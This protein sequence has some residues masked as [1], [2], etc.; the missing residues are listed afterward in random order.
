M[1]V[2][3][4]ARAGKANLTFTVSLDDTSRAKK[5]VSGILDS[6]SRSSVKIIGNIAKLSV[7][8]VGMRSHSGI[9]ATLFS[10]LAKSNINIQLISTSE[11]KISVAIDLDKADEA[12]R[13]VHQAFD[14]DKS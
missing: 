7:V 1:I 10:A 11:I 14:L 2:Q 9:A 5:A 13:V 3:N 12:C 8:G 4:I 6:I